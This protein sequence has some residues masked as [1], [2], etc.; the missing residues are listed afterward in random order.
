MKEEL[1]DS[2]TKGPPG[3]FADGLCGTKAIPKELDDPVCFDGAWIE[4]AW[5]DDPNYWACGKKPDNKEYTIC[6]VETGVWEDFTRFDDA[7]DGD[8]C[9][10]VP[11]G[12][13]YSVCNHET[14]EW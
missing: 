4:F 5:L 11:D 12:K 13:M 1:P 3:G 9:G 6:N 10:A 14:R 7:S 8:V 2:V